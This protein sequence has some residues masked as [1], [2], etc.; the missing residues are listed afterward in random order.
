M[1]K[2]SHSVPTATDLKSRMNIFKQSD[3][4]RLIL[5]AFTSNWLRRGE[6]DSRNPKRNNA[7]RSHITDART[8]FIVT[9]CCSTTIA[10]CPRKASMDGS[11]WAFCNIQHISKS[12][13][14]TDRQTAP[15]FREHFVTNSPGHTGWGLS[16]QRD[17][18]SHQTVLTLDEW[19][20]LEI[21]FQ[22]PVAGWH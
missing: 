12:Y 19:P 2:R 1:G 6:K 16:W 18:I 10:P 11:L 5:G 13:R 7:G 15:S 3:G 8:E 22:R 17:H 14:Q 21:R 9:S 4:L 20:E